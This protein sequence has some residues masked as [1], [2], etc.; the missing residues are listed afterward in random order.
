MVGCCPLVVAGSP[1]SGGHGRGRPLLASARPAAAYLGQPADHQ[2][3]HPGQLPGIYGH[4]WAGR[5]P[6]GVRYQPSALRPEGDCAA[7]LPAKPEC[8]PL[9]AAPAAAHAADPAPGFGGHAA[10]AGH[11][12]GIG[13]AHDQQ[14]GPD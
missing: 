1:A 8:L 10:A 4:R 9:P 2:S 6:A 13:A 12:A 7:G 5:G 3:R 14:P 11:Y